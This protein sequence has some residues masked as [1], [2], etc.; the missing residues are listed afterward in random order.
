MLLVI[1]GLIGTWWQ[2]SGSQES[3]W[4]SA[5]RLAERRNVLGEAARLEALRSWPE[6]PAVP[7]LADSPDEVSI[8]PVAYT[9][10]GATPPVPDRPSAAP[11][12]LVSAQREAMLRQFL[13]QVRSDELRRVLADPGLILYTDEEMPKAYQFFDGAFPGVHS[14]EY[15]ISANGSEPFGNGN[16]EFPWSTPAGTHRATSVST[17]R[18][19]WLPTDS[20][21]VRWPVVW[22]QQYAAGE[23]AASYA[24]TFPLGTVVGEVLTQRA[25]D[26]HDYTFEIRTRRR[27]VGYWEV[28]V[29][30]P[31]PTAQSLAAR[32]K[33]LRSNWRETPV[34]VELCEHLTARKTMPVLTLADH[35]PNKRTFEQSLAVDELPPVGDDA[36]VAELLTTTPF[37][38]AAGEN[39][40][41]LADGLSPR[42]PT[43]KAPFHVIPAGYDAGFVAVDS[44]SCTRCHD[45]VNQPVRS[46]D[47][48]R[49][50]YGHIRGSDGIFSFHP[51]APECISHNGYSNP[52]EMR[53]D[54]YWAGITAPFDA[55]VHG[56]EMYQG[57]FRL[58]GGL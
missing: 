7:A 45:T 20:H 58:E 37:R 46:F 17:F 18:F 35:Q 12:R 21:G 56:P 50:W 41:E 27:E 16:R 5:P 33:Q 4:R 23:S 42:A 51:F 9:A 26:Q 53:R 55:R 22:H 39:W 47:P 6:S 48:G 19:I 31:F 14:A 44:H 57:L 2:G 40:R 29:L 34:L 43:T 30:R 52:V 25:P 8:T 13:P 38:S 49:D 11:F 32:I 10:A 28:D 3:G 54:L 15:N 1:G 36:L 24:W